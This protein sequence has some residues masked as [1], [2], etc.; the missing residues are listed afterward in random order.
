[1][2]PVAVGIVGVLLLLLGLMAS[3]VYAASDWL[4]IK[5]MADSQLMVKPAS[6]K[7]ADGYAKVWTN[8]SFY[9]VKYTEDGLAYRSNKLLMEFEC[10]Q[11]VWRVQMAVLTAGLNGSGAVVRSIDLVTPWQRVGG[12]SPEEAVEQFACQ[13]K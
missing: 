3:P 12:D 1:M 9:R 2:R 6:L 8:R 11:D 13:R 7:Q 10:G 5:K 4:L